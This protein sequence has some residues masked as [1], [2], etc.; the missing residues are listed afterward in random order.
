MMMQSV[1]MKI[2]VTLWFAI[3]SWAD[4]ETLNFKSKT[5]HEN[6]KKLADQVKSNQRDYS[7]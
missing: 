7:D 2:E 6:V 3:F 4:F 5:L 1:V